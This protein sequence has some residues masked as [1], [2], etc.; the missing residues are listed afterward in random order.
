VRA[1]VVR[2]LR[3]Y[4][5]FGRA[6]RDQDGTMVDVTADRLESAERV[7]TYRRRFDAA[8]SACVEA[9]SSRFL[10]AEAARCSPW[11]R[12]NAVELLIDGSQVF[13]SMFAAIAA[14]RHSIHLETYILEA[15]GPGQRLAELLAQKAAQGVDVRLMFDSLVSFG[16]DRGYFDTLAARGVLVREFNPVLPWRKRFRSAINLRTHRKLLIVDREVAF[17]GGVNF[18]RVYS[19]GSAGV[20]R[21]T[22]EAQRPWRDT[23]ARLC[24]PIVADLQALFLEHWLEQGGTSGAAACEPIRERGSAWLALA[25]SA[26]GSRRNPLYRTLLAT[27]RTATRRILITTAYFVPTRRVVRELRRAAERGVRVALMAPSRSDSWS[28]AHA[29]RGCYGELLAS[30]VEI[31]DHCTSMLHSKTI[32][33]D[34]DW[35]SFGSSNMDWRSLLHN[36]EANIIALDRGLASEL[37]EHFEG[38]AASCVRITIDS[39]SKRPWT[40]QLCERLVRPF[41][42]ML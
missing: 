32:V 26:A 31:Y 39:W 27:L 1:G 21:D 3:A 25:A 40:S 13:D 16:T 9:H 7:T 6:T 29:G 5:R 15:D 8:S 33:I 19:S 12:G 35:C 36:A 4:P 11:R 37:V 28:A 24:G 41:Q 42:F 34:D 23:H 10:I 38:D 30:G 2:R 20:Q 17:I 22:A 18:S 14:A